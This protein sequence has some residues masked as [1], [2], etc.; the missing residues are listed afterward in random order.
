MPEFLE[1]LSGSFFC[2]PLNALYEHGVTSRF[3]YETAL[4]TLYF[5]RFWKSLDSRLGKAEKEAVLS[6]IG[7]KIDLLNLE[8]LSRAKQYYNLSREALSGCLIPVCYR[9]TQNQLLELADSSGQEEFIRILKTTRYGNRILKEE[10]PSFGSLLNTIYQKSRRKNPYSAAALNSYF[11]F[12]EEEIRKIITAIE[13][14][15]YS[16][17]GNEILSC[18]AG[19]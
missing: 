17:D 8:W 5:T 13:G 12:K 10:K 18:L 4:D 7:E 16:L 6:S 15:R 9:L 3:E 19:N 14:I 2:K 11:Y 1:N